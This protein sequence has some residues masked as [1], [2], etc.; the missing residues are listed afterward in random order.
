MK[1]TTLTRGT[2][3]LRWSATAPSRLPSGR[4]R[5]QRRL[6]ATKLLASPERKKTHVKGA[7]SALALSP[8]SYGEH[9]LPVQVEAHGGNTEM[10]GRERSG[11]AASSRSKRQ[12][13]AEAQVH[14]GDLEVIS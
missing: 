9:R 10:L 8:S 13:D 11:K 3:T 6:R 4:N 12:E 2:Q 14:H 7:A 1:L 5:Q